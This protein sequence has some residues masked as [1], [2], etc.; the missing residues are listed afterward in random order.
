[1]VQFTVARSAPRH[2]GARVLT[3]GLARCSIS[4]FERRDAGV[5]ARP[6]GAHSQMR[7]V[8]GTAFSLFLCLLP[9]GAHGQGASVVD[10]YEVLYRQKLLGKRALPASALEVSA[11][12]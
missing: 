11:G 7:G 6:E 12:N 10:P 4:A 1:M 3:A 8:R 2:R 9:A 5:R